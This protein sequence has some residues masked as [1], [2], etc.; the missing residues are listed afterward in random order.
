MKETASAL[1]VHHES[2]P[3]DKLERALE[4]QSVKVYHASNC[5]EASG[6][7]EN[8]K[9]PHLVFTDTRL[10]DAT[11]ADVLGL[12]AKAPATVNVIVVA[13]FSDMR[14]YIDTI[15]RGAFDFLVPPF[16]RFDLAHVVQCALEN[17]ASRSHGQAHAA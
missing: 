14:L 10:P 5:Q 1:F 11:W 9:P 15:E 4:G 12:V 6:L 8:P 7:L 2:E 16:V 17:V 13:R 3:F